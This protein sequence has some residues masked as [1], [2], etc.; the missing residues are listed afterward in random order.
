MGFVTVNYSLN[1]SYFVEK[2]VFEKIVKKAAADSKLIKL[3]SFEVEMLKVKNDY[4][5]EINVDIKSGA[6][7][8]DAISELQTNIEDLSMNL[9]ESKPEN[10]TIVIEGDF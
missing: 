10:I 1:Q 7:Y 9:I 4:K 6:S 8:K 2:G 3:N 5:I